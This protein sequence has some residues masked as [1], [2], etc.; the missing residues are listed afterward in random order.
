MLWTV[1]P[2]DE[3][4]DDDDGGGSVAEMSVG[5]ATIVVHT[6]G[7]GR[8]RVQRLL[9]TNPHHYLRPEWQPGAPWVGGEEVR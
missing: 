2:M 9:S 3:L 8:R 1:V 5:G 7:A 6:D 4:L